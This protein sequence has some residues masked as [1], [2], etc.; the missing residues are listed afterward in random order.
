MQHVGGVEGGRRGRGEEE[1]RGTNGEPAR[2]GILDEGE[3]RREG[4]GR[5]CC[6]GDGID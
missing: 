6:L 5:R 3:E 1:G 4:K 2:D